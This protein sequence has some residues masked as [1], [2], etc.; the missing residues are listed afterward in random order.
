MADGEGLPAGGNGLPNC[1]GKV[2]CFVLVG[3]DVGIACQANEGA[4]D[5]LFVGKESIAKMGDQILEKNESA[6]VESLD[7]GGRRRQGKDDESF[8]AGGRILDVQG[9][10]NGKRWDDFAGILFGV[11]EETAMPPLTA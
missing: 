5:D 7:S 4:T 6:F 2:V 3:G 1:L 9:Q 11:P 10:A 8:F